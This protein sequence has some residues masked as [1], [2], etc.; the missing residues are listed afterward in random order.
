[1]ADV[2][3]WPTR[4]YSGT[5]RNNSTVTPYKHLKPIG[6][7][8]VGIDLLRE[9]RIE[10]RLADDT[11]VVSDQSVVTTTAAADTL[12][13]AFVDEFAAALAHT[14]AGRAKRTRFRPSPVDPAI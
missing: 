1:V 12:P 6:A 14:I 9:A 11:D 8:G 2:G 7:F 10:V 13:D 4:T 3:R 5:K